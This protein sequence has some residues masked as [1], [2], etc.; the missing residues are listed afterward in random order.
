MLVREK[1]HRTPLNEIQIRRAVCTSDIE[2]CLL[3]KTP[4]GPFRCAVCARSISFR[5]LWCWRTDNFNSVLL[6]FVRDDT[7]NTFS[8]RKFTTI[9]R[10]TERILSGSLS[11]PNSLAVTFS[12]GGKKNIIEESPWIIGRRRGL[13][14]I[15]ARSSKGPRHCLQTYP[16]PRA[17]AFRSHRKRNRNV[18]VNIDTRYRGTL[19]ARRPLRAGVYV[20]FRGRARLI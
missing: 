10:A 5:D 18:P 2:L 17:R 11:A 3:R 16:T 1:N 13:N 6:R 19:G 4:R 15:N 7:R 8:T 9:R 20:A 12:F 14:E